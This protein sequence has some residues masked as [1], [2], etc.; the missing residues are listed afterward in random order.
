MRD[1]NWQFPNCLFQAGHVAMTQ[2]PVA[3]TQN[4]KTTSRGFCILSSRSFL[5]SGEFM[6]HT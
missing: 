2:L 4:T 5:P 3:M 1:V 6:E